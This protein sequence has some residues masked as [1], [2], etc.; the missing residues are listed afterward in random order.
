MI[1]QINKTSLFATFNVECFNTLEEA[2]STM[3]PS[4]VEYYLSDLCC[5][6]QDTYLNKREIEKSIDV[7]EYCIHI[8]Y[9]DD[10]YLEMEQSSNDYETGSLW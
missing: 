7:G 9:N 4:M 3:A 1:T 10:I 5:D 2:M 6:N 8:D